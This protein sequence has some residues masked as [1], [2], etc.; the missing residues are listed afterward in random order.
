MDR[1]YHTYLPILCP[2]AVL[3]YTYVVTRLYPSQDLGR[4]IDV[5]N[6]RRYQAKYHQQ[7]FIQGQL[8]LPAAAAPDPAPWSVPTDT[9]PNQISPTDVGAQTI[10]VRLQAPSSPE[11]KAMPN[12]SQQMPWS[13][14]LSPTTAATWWIIVNRRQ[15]FLTRSRDPSEAVWNI[16]C[17]WSSNTL[18]GGFPHHYD[19]L[20]D[21]SLFYSCVACAPPLTIK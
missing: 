3:L 18:V 14:K 6:W 10:S 7:A 12:F 5:L 2:Y 11:A 15:G 9:I 21:S 19:Q 8:F 13:H 16:D 20:N 4:G 17:W 1:G